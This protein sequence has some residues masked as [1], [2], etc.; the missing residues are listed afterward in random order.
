MRELLVLVSTIFLGCRDVLAGT[1]YVSFPNLLVPGLSLDVRVTVTMASR[2][3]YFKASL[4]RVADNT[5]IS[6]VS[7]TVSPGTSKLTKLHVPEV[8]EKNQ[9][10]IVVTGTGGLS[11]NRESIIRVEQN[12]ILIFVQ[13][14]KS[15]YSGGQEVKYRA[16]F[17]RPNMLPYEGP[18]VLTVHD[19][20]DNMIKTEQFNNSMNGV[21][22][23][24]LF[25]A[26]EPVFGIW[27]ITA[28]VPKMATTYAKTFEVRDYVLPKFEVQ[29]TVAKGI[30]ETE[31]SFQVS[32][33]ARFTFE[34]DVLGNCTLLIYDPDDLTTYLEY[35]KPIYGAVNFTIQ[36]SDLK[37]KVNVYSE[38]KVRAT[39]S[40]NAT[41]LTMVNENELEIIKTQSR[42]DVTKINKRD[43][44]FP[45]STYQTPIKVTREGK[46]IGTSG[47]LTVTPIGYTAH[48]K[49]CSYGLWAGSKYL[50]IQKTYEPS[51]AVAFDEKGFGEIL[52]QT[53]QR[54]QKIEVKFSNVSSGESFTIYTFSENVSRIIALSADKVYAK[55]GETITIQ[56]ASSVN[57]EGHVT[58][59]VFSRGL[60]LRTDSLLLEQTRTASYSVVLTADM[61]PQTYVS[62]THITPD[63]HLLKEQI[64][65][66]VEGLPFRNNVSVDVDKERYQPRDSIQL[67]FK[68]NPESTVY[69]LIEDQRN[70]LLGVQND[71]FAY[72]ITDK[73]RSTGQAYNRRKR[74]VSPEDTDFIVLT[75]YTLT[76]RTPVSSLSI[77]NPSSLMFSCFPVDFLMK[78]DPLD[79]PDF[80][81]KEIDQAL[82]L[83]EFVRSRFPETWL[84]EEFETGPDGCVNISR[85][86]PDTVTTWVTSAFASDRTTGFGIPED[87][88]EINVRRKFFLTMHAP[89]SLIVGEKFL[90][91]VTVFN[92]LGKFVT[93]QILIERSDDSRQVPASTAVEDGQ[94]HS[95]F[96]E[97]Q[98]NKTGVLKLTARAR[99]GS[100]FQTYAVDMVEKEIIVSPQG[101]QK[102]INHPKFI[103]LLPHST[104]YRE[105]ISLGNYQNAVP[106][107]QQ[108]YVKIT[109]D[110]MT[111]TMTGLQDLIRMPYGCGEQ[112]MLNFAPD[113]FVTNYMS[114]TGQL[115]EQIKTKAL[116]CILQG[117]QRELTFKRPDG[118]YSAFLQDP[119]GGTWLTAYVLKCFH[120]AK[121]LITIDPAVLSS[122]TRW[123][124]KR[125]TSEGSFIEQSPIRHIVHV[126]TE[127]RMSAFVIISLMEVSK[128]STSSEFPTL[129]TVTRSGIAYLERKLPLVNDAYS[130]SI[131]CYALAL[132]G[133]SSRQTCFSKLQNS[134]FSEDD[135]IHWPGS[136]TSQTSVTARDIEA[137][138]YGLLTYIAMGRFAEAQPI[139]KWLVGQ[140]NAYG[141]YRSTQDT[142]IAVQALNEYSLKKREFATN[143]SVL[144][145]VAGEDFTHSYAITSNNNKASHRYEVISK[146]S[147]LNITV[148]G[149]GMAIVDVV[150]TFYV[151][152]TATHKDISVS[153]SIVK[154]SINSLI[155][156]PVLRWNGASTSNLLMMEIEMPTGFDAD[157]DFVKNQSV[158]QK[159][160]TFGQT[161]VLYFNSLAPL[162]SIRVDV[163]LQRV[164]QVVG[165]QPCHITAYDYYEPEKQSV[166]TYES[167]TLKSADICDVC[168]LC[169]MCTEG[170]QLSGG[171]K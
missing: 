77:S 40:D 107:T 140:R 30:K 159:H 163:K 50:D 97:I 104:V 51:F 93:V 1:Y 167:G 79:G 52:I 109:G 162:A 80:S 74:S 161:F 59:E 134:K 106:G 21:V 105:T 85:T 133:S 4:Q 34:T 35:S 20:G 87:K 41:F 170:T 103:T 37:K 15:R 82:D 26:K 155:I 166:T 69:A 13:T 137:T 12:S 160:E 153:V 110:I 135:T 63:G 55:V 100:F 29:I 73:L 95:T 94:G 2:P 111:P 130:L 62:A 10:K 45:G 147:Y 90:L 78:N 150:E 151:S 152:K 57:L 113:V 28:D 60:L 19:G 154:E 61:V 11:F 39:V 165:N 136:S 146:Q 98:S 131:T 114:V 68:A 18:V 112:N 120:Q 127:L 8:L 23:S 141:G 164:D 123:L 138:A 144:V 65:L 25:L 31:E 48:I 36:M 7:T 91:Q 66:L 9:H 102:T 139:A 27:S 75:D 143:P 64:L 17:L 142:V 168:P 156:R 83:Q 169:R 117:Y 118:S 6:T 148:S 70:R 5:A 46:P 129:N 128:S 32:V 92:N 3:V 171:W 125:Q 99:A 132:F 86:L 108:I 84:W 53:P 101:I 58:F 81:F 119:Y 44:F 22:S 126:F 54:Y 89:P 49:R 149:D 124:L 145:N 14:D 43:Y 72:Q 122:A 116:S 33:R 24:T 96:V 56:A 71:I 16:I 38:I 158:I 67:I 47:T 42:I 157:S 76:T 121:D 115:T 88:L